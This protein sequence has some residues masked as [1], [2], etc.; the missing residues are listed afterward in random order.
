LATDDL[1]P[2]QALINAAGLSVPQVTTDFFG[3]LWGANPDLG[4][5]EFVP[6]PVDNIGLNALIAPIESTDTCYGATND[7]IVELLNAGGTVIDF[8][9]SS[10]VITMNVSGSTTQTL[11]ATVNSNAINGGNPLAIGTAINVNLG[12]LNMTTVGVYNFD[13]YITTV[14]DSLNG[15]DT[16][17]TTVTVLAPLG[18]VI[19]GNDT[20]CGGD[21]ITLSVA[22]SV[23]AVQW[24]EL[25]GGAFVD[26][27]GETSTTYDVTINSS[28]SFRVVACGV[29]LSDT[30]NVFPIIIN[31]PTVAK[32]DPVIVSCGQVGIDTLIMAGGTGTSQEWYDA[33]LDGN[34]VNTGD[35]LLYTYNTATSSA[36]LDTFYVESKTGN[37]ADTIIPA[38][39]TSVYSGSA[40]GY[41]FV[42]PID[43]I[44]TGLEVDVLAGAGSQN[45]AV[46]RTIGN[47]PWAIWNGVQVPFTTLYYGIN[48]APTGYIPVNIP[49]KAGEVIAILGQR[50][51]ANQYAPSGAFTIGGISTSFARFIMQ[52]NL[53][54]TAPSA[55]VQLGE[56][57]TGNISNVNFTISNGC[58]S[59][60]TMVIGEVNC[61]V[62]VHAIA[63]EL[64]GISISPNPSNGVFT[65]NI[66][67]PATE[68][69]NV[70]ARDAQG[71][72][73]YTENLTVNGT[74]S[75]NLDFTS[76]A[77]GIYYLI[78][79]TETGSRVEKLIIQ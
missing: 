37:G 36:S 13:G 54:V 79:Q 77:K 43:F 42:A 31:A 53:D 9:N 8:A 68:N 66:E 7:V 61:A 76:F 52:A 18:G 55:A 25:V 14:N 16:L 22:G 57:G 28:A 26:I 47:L 33:P 71:R 23:G 20:V 11:T 2:R 44:I 40:R 32:N 35:T 65:L 4:A 67:T 73:V 74:Y 51:T 30:L 39:G 34:S 72:T 50:G 17:A 56:N 5:I 78:L 29:A 3:N 12:T 69:V 24:Q 62:G 15:N 38:I 6:A 70:T 21:D 10:T 75:N 27:T 48:Q 60:R 45:V 19:N 1:T 63:S 46:L 59:P 41:H 49:I 58:V 64:G